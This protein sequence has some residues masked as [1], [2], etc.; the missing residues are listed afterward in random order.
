MSAPGFTYQWATTTN[1]PAGA[2]PWSGHALKVLPPTSYQTPDV[3][4]VG[5]Y[6]NYNLN[7][8]GKDTLALQQFTAGI[9][10][11]NW[12]ANITAVSILA[13]SSTSAVCWDEANHR[14]VVATYSSGTT[15]N[16]RATADG[17]STWVSLGGTTP[18]GASRLDIIADISSDGAG[19]LLLV[20][21]GT[22]HIPDGAVWYWNGSSWTHETPTLVS[23][24]TLFRC[25]Y[26]NST[27]VVFGKRSLTTSFDGPTCALSGASNALTNS[28]SWPNLLMEDT[29]NGT[30]MVLAQSSSVLICGQIQTG[31]NQNNGGV[32]TYGRTTDGSTWTAQTIAGA[33]TAW[34]LGD[35]SYD[36]GNAVFVAM[37][38]DGGTTSKIFTSTDG[39][40]WT[41]VT[42][43]PNVCQTLTCSGSTWVAVNAT[44]TS[45]VASAYYSTDMGLTWRP[46]CNFTGS[47]TAD[48]SPPTSSGVVLPVVGKA[49]PYQIAVLGYTQLCLSFATG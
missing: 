11:N 31:A 8:V 2:D 21:T 32:Y 17:G 5:E 15:L 34:T 6:Y 23:A 7:K 12:R 27:W 28:A 10:A 1:Y 46:C 38:W 47:P 36:T 14:W 29:I 43:I 35:L 48:V 26:F 33:N 3:S 9:Q 30:A 16:I 40:S 42:S 41:A 39:I 25:T 45:G 44:F 18:L 4:W 24:T 37:F 19:N 20:T 49:S 22:Y 13:S